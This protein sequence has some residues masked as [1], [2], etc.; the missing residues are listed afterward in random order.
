MNKTTFA[1]VAATA[2]LAFLPLQELTSPCSRVARRPDRSRSSVR[3]PNERDD[4][5]TIKV[6]VRFPDGF[7]FLFV[8]EGPRVEGEGL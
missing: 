2:T 3:V 1:A 4:K 6:D 8:P 5:G 7:Y